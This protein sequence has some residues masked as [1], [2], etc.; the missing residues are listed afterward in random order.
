MKLKKY[1]LNFILT[2]GEHW[3]ENR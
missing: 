2:L 1:E 3:W